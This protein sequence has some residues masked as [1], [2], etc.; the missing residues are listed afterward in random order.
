MPFSSLKHVQR[1]VKLSGNYMTSAGGQ[2]TYITTTVLNSAV[3]VQLCVSS[4]YMNFDQYVFV[5]WA[6]I[7]C[8]VQKH[9]TC[10]IKVES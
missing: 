9:A 3:A 1:L 10:Y 7:I 6:E 4:S 8:E 2:T 5:K